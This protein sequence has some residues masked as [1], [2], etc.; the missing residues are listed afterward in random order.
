MGS[1]AADLITVLGAGA[2]IE[3]SG[4]GDHV[5]VRSSLSLAARAHGAF[6]P[7]CAS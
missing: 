6:I 2:G 3:A 1:C 5:A 7:R 4:S